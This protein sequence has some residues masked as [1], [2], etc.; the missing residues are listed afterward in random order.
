MKLTLLRFCIAF[1][2]IGLSACAVEE[3]ANSGSDEQP[4]N[5]AANGTLLNDGLIAPTA[6]EL[7]IGAEPG[8]LMF[9]WV[10]RENSAETDTD[11]NLYMHDSR[12][13]LETELDTQIN[14]GVTDYVLPVTPHQLAWD[15][16]SYR[17][18]ICSAS[19]CLSSLRMPIESLLADAVAVIQPSDADLFPSYASHMALNGEG[20]V[21]VAA[22]P[23]AVN[24][25]VHF[26]QSEQWVFASVLTPSQ[27]NQSESVQ[28]RVAISDS[29]DTIAIGAIGANTNPTIAIFERL[30]ENWIE[31]TRISAFGSNLSNAVGTNTGGQLW[32]TQSLRMRLSA[33][34][35]RLAI[36]AQRFSQTDASASFASSNNRLE[37]FERDAL[38]WALSARLELPSQHSRLIS[39]STS[40]ALDQ[41]NALS[42]MDGLLYLHEYQLNANQWQAAQVQPI[43]DINAGYDSTIISSTNGDSVAIGGWES[44]GNTARA[45][46]AWK[47]DHSEAGW[48]STDSVRLPS[49][50]DQ[51]AQLRLAGDGELN[52]LA[53]GWQAAQSASLNFFSVADERWQRL[54]SFPRGISLSFSRDSSAAVV[55]A[56]GGFFGFSAAQ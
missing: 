51:S 48:I 3:G 8:A 33:D 2:T 34:G 5:D 10:D 32:D 22:N 18:E 9:S 23:Q 35:N 55:S 13:G 14:A 21:A 42:A 20:T 12:T 16:I 50:T 7:N 37:V 17:V 53:V 41:I 27:F 28:L 49:T 15:S 11:T 47:L 19:D 46:V 43:E 31:T 56:S 40:N 36:G 39:F 30:G 38:N 44:D 45:A 26:R 24:A 54:F 1:F 29:G 52:T 4:Q 6:P 25:T